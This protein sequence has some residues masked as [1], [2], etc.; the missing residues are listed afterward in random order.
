MRF[1]TEDLPQQVRSKI[2]R[3]YIVDLFGDYTEVEGLHELE[4][5]IGESIS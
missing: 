2:I 3:A 5:A 4:D 1:E